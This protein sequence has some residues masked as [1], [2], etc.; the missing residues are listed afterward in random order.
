MGGA[1]HYTSAQTWMH[2]TSGASRGL[3]DNDVSRA[4]L[5]C[6]MCTL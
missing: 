1:C 3:G 4:F 6:D 5:G 2:N